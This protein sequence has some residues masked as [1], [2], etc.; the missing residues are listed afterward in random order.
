MESSVDAGFKEAMAQWIELKKQ[1][2]AAKSDLKVLTTQEK[3]LA[4]FIKEYMLDKQ[5]DACNTKDSTGSAA[6]V[7]CKTRQTKTGFSKALVRL[8]LMRYFKDDVDRV[9]HVM[10]VIAECVEFSEKSSISLKT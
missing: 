3:N 1:L 10:D 4:K 7:L 9:N 8:G 2:A 6:K 5:I